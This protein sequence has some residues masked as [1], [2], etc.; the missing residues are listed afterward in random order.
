MEKLEPTTTPRDLAQ[1]LGT[2]YSNLM[3]V[4][5][6]LKNSLYTEFEISKKSGG[7]RKIRAPKDQLKILQRRLKNLLENLYTPHS[8][9]SA[10]IKGRGIVYNAKKHVKRGIVFNIDLESFYDCI[11]FGR[12]RGLL[13]SP[14]FSLNSETAKIIAHICTVDQILPQGAPTSPI[15]SNMICR[16]LDRELSFIAKNNSAYYSRYADDITFS[17]KKIIPTEIY[18]EQSFAEGIAK[19]HEKILACLYANKF[20]INESKT[21]INI[22]SER[23]TVTGLTVNKKVNIDRRYIRTTKAMIHS[24]SHGI[25]EANEAFNI[26]FP[27][28]ST[29]LETMVLGRINYIG[30][31]KGKESTVYQTL[32]SKF[33][34]IS[35]LNLEAAMISSSNSERLEQKMHFYAHKHRTILEKCVWVVSFDGIEELDVDSQLIQG[36]AFIVS[37]NRILTAAHIFSKAGNSDYCFLYRIKEPNLKYK[38]RIKTSDHISDIAELEFQ[39]KDVPKFPFLHVAKNL[40]THMGYKLAISGF[41]L[42]ALGHQSVT[43]I[44]C[45]VTNTFSQSTYTRVQVDKEIQSGNSG[46]P[47]INFYGKV[48]GMALTGQSVTIGD[49]GKPH[50]EGMNAF[51]S[52]IHFPI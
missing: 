51:I 33:N 27:E 50:L 18:C 28:K 12:I 47:I 40:S 9:A 21:R 13:I 49:D 30:M 44:P 10:F 43:I 23:Q 20:S 29:R 1:L 31:I 15:I 16:K 17:F 14:P 4:V 6:G 5:Y 48:V 11:H 19:P 36:S 32:A 39:D 25:E 22:S 35:S 42:L 45:T 3:Y 34:G 8:A 26:K 41:P 7:L 38:A 2:T 52:A 46:G 37:Q 24:L